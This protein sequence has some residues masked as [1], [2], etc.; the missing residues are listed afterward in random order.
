M[1][2]AKNSF[3]R[4]A[5]H[6]LGAGP[7]AEIHFQDSG[8][9]SRGRRRVLRWVLESEPETERWQELGDGEPR[10]VVSDPNFAAAGGVGVGVAAILRRSVRPR[11][12]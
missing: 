6:R 12:G 3:R 10:Q 8:G 7:A 2:R 5:G 11:G 9:H 4:D 1:A